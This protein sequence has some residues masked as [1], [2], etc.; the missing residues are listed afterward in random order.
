MERIKTFYEKHTRIIFYS[1]AFL[2]PFL[3]TVFLFAVRGIYPFGGITFL[4]K[5]MYQQYTP[6]FYEFYRKLKNG[7]SLWYSWNAGLGANF[8]AVIAYY[9]ASPLNL[10]CVLFPENSILEFMTY[11]VVIKTGLMGLTASAYLAYHFRRHD[12]AMAFFSLAYSM[13][14]FMAAYNWNIEWMDVLFAAPLALLGLEK[15]KDGGSPLIYYL[16]L[17]YA[18]FTNYYLSIMLCIYLTLYFIVLNVIKGFDIKATLNFLV[19]SVLSGLT[20]AVLILPEYYSL[21]FTTFTNIRFPRELTVYLSPLELFTSHLIGVTPETGLGHYPNIYCGLLTLFMIVLYAFS[22]KEKLKEKIC[23]ISLLMFFLLSFD[24]NILNFIWHGFNYPDSLPARQGYLYTLLLMMMAYEAFLSLREIKQNILFASLV[25]SY[26]FIMLITFFSGKERMDDISR[27]INYVFALS[28]VIILLLYRSAPSK[29]HFPGNGQELIFRYGLLLILLSEI[30][31]NMYLTGSR[32]VKRTDYFRKYDDFKVLNDEKALTDTE[33]DSPLSR[34]DEIGR[35]VR[36]DSMMI[37]YPSLSFFSSTTNGLLIKYLQKYGIMNSRVFYLSDGTTAVTSFL[38]GQKY[39]FV[40]EGKICTSEDIASPH[41][42][43]NGSVLY[44]YNDYLPN[45][46]VLRVNDK[47]KEKLFLSASEAENIIDSKT[48]APNSEYPPSDAQNTLIHDLNI[49]GTALMRYGS[50]ENGTLAHADEKL[51]VKYSDTCHLYAY[52][53]SKTK[54]E[55]KISFSDG[56]TLG[57]VPFNKYRYFVDLGYRAEGTKAF[58]IPEDKEDRDLDIEFFRLNTS[59]LSSLASNINKA[60]KLTGIKLEDDS[61]SGEIDM[62]S[63]GQLIIN[64]PYEPGWTLYVDNKETPIT[65]FDGIWISASLPEG[66]HEIRMDFFPKG[67]KTG[68]VV[69]I[70]SLI[71]ALFLIKYESILRKRAA[72]SLKTP[73][74]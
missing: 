62:L 13:S 34:A 23:Y 43:S 29:I 24:I 25:F 47:A 60:E 19:F 4:K 33:D 18:I 39:I 67:L 50:F 70:I 42:F 17:S 37:D 55:I 7:N 16:S 54:G 71:L 11:S 66:R 57:K 65:L 46:Y 2:L 22:V 3:C 48:D 49:S 72:H 73:A 10:L 32:S 21:R 61:L 36:N 5:D 14:A 38:S 64:V 41:I 63:A 44:Q 9:L 1:A 12:P 68:A 58:F 56:T 40:P 28:I 45:G 59:V 27:I 51:S 74:S 30:V 15:L 35:N 69:S 53:A 8:L 20:A 52:N 26:V 31:L 6:F